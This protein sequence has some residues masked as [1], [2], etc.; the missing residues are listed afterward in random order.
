MKLRNKETKKFDIQKIFI[1]KNPYTPG[2]I[3]SFIINGQYIEM[4]RNVMY[5]D[6]IFDD[7]KNYLEILIN[8]SDYIKKY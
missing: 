4:S 6:S 2:Y 8:D 5:I 1:E 7:I 3:C